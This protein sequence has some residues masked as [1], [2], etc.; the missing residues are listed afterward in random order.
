MRYE[1][2]VPEHF[3]K[4]PFLGNQSILINIECPASRQN[5]NI[6]SD[7]LKPYIDIAKRTPAFIIRVACPECR[8]LLSISTT[9]PDFFVH[10][11]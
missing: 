3:A 4:V 8:E 11:R 6:R 2:V 10:L 7:N 1:F 9:S 5:A